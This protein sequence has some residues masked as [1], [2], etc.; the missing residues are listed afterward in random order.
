MGMT[1]KF[2]GL[3]VYIRLVGLVVRW[4]L[5]ELVELMELISLIGKY[6]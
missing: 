6:V 5:V 3:K 2:L 4:E 1:D